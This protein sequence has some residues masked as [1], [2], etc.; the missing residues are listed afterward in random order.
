MLGQTNDLAKLNDNNDLDFLFRF[1]S[2]L[3]DENEDSPYSNVQLNGKFHDFESFTSDPTI[4]NSP[5]YINLN[6]QSLN[7]KH[8]NLNEYV[9][10]LI[11]KGL[12]IEI[13][14]L[15]EIWTI[16]H[17]QLLNIEGFHPLI[18]KQRAG[19]RGGGVGFYIKNSISFEII[20]DCSPFENKILESI[21]LLLSLSNKSKIYVTSVYRSNGPLP[22]IS[23]N[24]QMQRFSL[25]FNDLLAKISIKRHVS[26]IFT[27]SNINLINE[28]PL[29]YGNYLN[30]IFSHGFLQLNTK[31]SRM[32]DGS[33]SLIDHIISNCK[34]NSFRTGSLISD[35]SDHFITFICN[36]K[37]VLPSQQKVVTSR[38][39]S[40]QNILKFKLALA[41]EHWLSISSETVTDSAYDA[42][43]SIYNFH[44]ANSFPLT[45][46]K[47]NKNLHK[48]NSYMSAGLLIS[49]GTKNNLHKQSL[50][51]PT[52]LI[53]NQYKQFR[54]LYAKTLRAAKI[55]HVQAKLKDCKGNSK[56]T[57][58]ILNECTG[59]TT[60]KENVDKITSNGTITEN[61]LEIANEFNNFFVKVGKEISDSVPTIERQPESYLV[62]PV[63]PIP[64]NLQNVTPD[65]LVK[66]V[67]DLKSKTSTDIDGVSSKM[68]KLVISEIKVPLSHIFNLSLSSG[69]FPSKLK[70]SKVVPIFKSGNRN[71]CDN[72]RPISLLCSIS[73]ILEKLVAK[74]LLDHLQ[75]NNLIYN[76]QYG[77]LP[78][79]S[80]EQNLLQVTNYIADALN[81]GMFCLGVF[82][83]LRKAFDV[84]SHKIL[85]KKLKNL[86]II[87]VNLK[88]FESYLS[89]RL[90]MVDINGTLSDEKCFNISVIQGS[91][92]GTILF[93][94]YINDFY[95]CTSLFT[96]LFADD[97][98][99]L[100]KHKNLQTL[101][102]YVN[103]ELQKVAN[104]FLAN[105]M[106]I[107]TSKTKFILFRT[108][109]KIVDE[110]ICKIFYNNNEI[111]KIE[112]QN[113]IFPIERIHNSGSTKNF[114]LLG[115]MLDEYLSFDSHITHMCS[116]ISKSLYIINRVRNTLPKESLV[117]LYYALIHSHISYC[118]S[119]FGSATSTSLSRIV[120]MQKR[121]IRIICNV[122]S[123][124]HTAPLFID[125]QILPFEKLITFSKL[126]FMH[127]FVH[128]RLPFSFNETWITNIERNPRLNLRNAQE[129]YIRPVNFIS[130]KRLPLFNFPSVWNQEHHSKSLPDFKFYQRSLKS[131]LLGEIIV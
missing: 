98:T 71:E 112:N 96:T 56:Q 18:Y 1:N 123:R 70:R 29:V 4:V 22:N 118:T 38:I 49:R 21:T 61:P 37:N 116:K 77:F 115:I 31:A 105:K 46:I 39:F 127:K 42:F 36:G 103:A 16:D 27:D 86:G 100:S 74:K 107:N 2:L 28:N 120:K 25:S 62:P 68:I 108:H 55:L 128:N 125:L 78:K 14:A 91:I 45:K 24:D 101:I 5:V 32:Y 11:A 67:K 58:K 65:Y 30:T 54:N 69:E 9:S 10:E 51:N 43:W 90:Q 33:I 81:E 6:V 99:C 82:I 88:W 40:E 53:I 47:F 104:W 66:I 130:L 92:L 50:S 44:F 80:T 60:K 17:P 41:N 89:D 124:S 129:F 110:N 26:F 97:G 119:V 114:K 63:I 113:K 48:I 131:R 126:K 13:I 12:N 102:D 109:G 117:S 83:D 79:R 93:L 57:W 52:P 75:S 84:C 95:T 76:H 122:P 23:A 35:I 94:C 87:G 121:A 111:G 34:S 15:Q 106:A 72:Y 85:L 73:K 59:R 20:E 8:A 19:M 3:T 7:S 64:F